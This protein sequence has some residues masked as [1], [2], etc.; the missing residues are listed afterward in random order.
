LN[1]QHLEILLGRIT[2]PDIVD[3]FASDHQDERRKIE[4]GMARALRRISRQN[5]VISVAGRLVTLATLTTIA[6]AIHKRSLVAGNDE[7]TGSPWYALVV[8]LFVASIVALNSTRCDDPRC[9]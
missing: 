4:I 8:E 1:Q 6:I 9:I 3:G 5:L 7:N 2:Q